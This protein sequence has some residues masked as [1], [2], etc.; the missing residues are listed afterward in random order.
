MRGIPNLH[1]EVVTARDLRGGAALVVA[2]LA[3]EGMTTVQG[4]EHIERGYVDL[5]RNLCLL[6]AEIDCEIV[7]SE[8]K[9]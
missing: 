9:E 6:G 8:S 2:G 5:C 1:G 4:G 7:E 3:A